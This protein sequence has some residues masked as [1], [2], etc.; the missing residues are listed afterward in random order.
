MRFLQTIL[1]LLLFT[2]LFSCGGTAETKETDEQT[3][4]VKENS[5]EQSKPMDLIDEFFSLIKAEDFK[6]SLS[7]FIEDPVEKGEVTLQEYID[8]INYISQDGTITTVSSEIVEQEDMP[9]Y[10]RVD[11]TL[12]FEEEKSSVK[13]VYVTDETGEWKLTIKGSLF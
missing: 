4:T 8:R 11:I 12:N 2:L 9:Q 5:S 1:L 10:T 7:L 6:G 13:W 3:T